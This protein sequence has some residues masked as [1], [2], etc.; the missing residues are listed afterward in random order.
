[1]ALDPKILF[2][3]EP[4][5]GLDPVT[6]AELDNLIVRINK[7]LDTTMVIVTHELA[8]IMAVAHRVIMLDGE[9]KNIIA[10]GAPS[11]LMEKAEDPRVRDFFARSPSRAERAEAPL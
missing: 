4:S 6:S 3:D 5:A 2:F 11:E 7:S 8:S 10:E 9:E 1:M